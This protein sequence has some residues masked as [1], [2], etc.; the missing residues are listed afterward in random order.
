VVY[1]STETHVFDRGP[2]PGDGRDGRGGA[3]A[4][5]FRRGA[6]P[7]G[8]VQEALPMLAGIFAQEP[9]WRTLTGRLPSVGLLDVS[10]E[11]LATI[12]AQG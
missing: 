8:R 9:N 10:P 2:R 5:V 12:L 1:G 11:T 6:L 3:V 4:L 7:L